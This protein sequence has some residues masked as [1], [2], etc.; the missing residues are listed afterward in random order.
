MYDATAIL[1]TLPDPFT[2]SQAVTAG[3]TSDVVQRLART[4]VALLAHPLH[5][6][7]HQTGAVARRWPVNLHPDETVHLTAI[8][9]EPRSR[10][11]ADR[12]LHHSDSVIND[13]ELWDGKPILS[14]PRIAADCLRVMLPRAG[15][16]VA[17]AAVRDGST[18]RP[19]S[20][21]WSWTGRS[22]GP[23][24]HGPWPPYRSSIPAEK[25]GS[26]RT[27]S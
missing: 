13:V 11:A 3:L 20:R 23:G 4:R 8:M 24:A 7:S 21:R 16:A 18:T 5:A 19:R 14:A 1:L 26:S 6:P 2:R 17:D 12:V 27:P 9:V 10:R 22:G 25:P 15:V